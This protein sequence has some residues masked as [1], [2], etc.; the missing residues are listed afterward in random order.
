[1]QCP[2]KPAPAC[3]FIVNWL[4]GHPE[5]KLALFWFVL[6]HFGSLLVCSGSFWVVLFRFGSF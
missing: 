5:S 3:D 1:M 2:E 6:G 4:E